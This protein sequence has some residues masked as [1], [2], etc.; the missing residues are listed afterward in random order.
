MK[1]KIPRYDPMIE[2]TGQKPK[3]SNRAVL[4]LL[5]A[6]L[7]ALTVPAAAQQPKK[8]PRVG[9]VTGNR[10]EPSVVEFQR[11]LRDLGY[12]E[13]KNILVEHRYTGEMTDRSPTIVAELVQLKLDVLVSTVPSTIRAAK[14]T[15]STIPIVFVTTGDP[16][17][18]G[19]VD[20]WA[21]PGGNITGL[22]R[23]TR[24]LSGKR[25]ELVKEVLPGIS[26]VG[27]LWA[28]SSTVTVGF[29]TYEAPARA[30]KLQIQS[31][32]VRGP[33]PDFE[34]AFR[35]AAKGHVRALVTVSNRMLTPYPKRLRTLP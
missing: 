14:Q 30:L 10:Q 28:S 11:A 31:I 33:N 32:E 20:N 2:V 7:L 22:T 3:V 16:V 5:C 4:S 8:V 34:R 29:K 19:L 6:W 15:T 12:V 13:G 1:T 27:V 9:F 26:R 17:A 35:D 18:E 25:L 21:R 24:D 23:L